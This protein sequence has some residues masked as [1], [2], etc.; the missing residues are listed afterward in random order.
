MKTA[1]DSSILLDVFLP[2]PEFGERSLAV[3]RRVYALGSL[4]VC[5]VAWAEASAHFAD[6]RLLHE[7]MD[8]AG[9]DFEPL[10][11][12]ASEEAGRLWREYCL[13]HRRP[14]QRVIADFLVGAHAFLQADA[15]LTRDRG[16]Y[17]PYFPKLKIVD[18]T[19]T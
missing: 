12:A 17:R 1:V 4:A 15:L 10:T 16:F 5:D 8:A 11:R 2:D 6:V 18:P 13:Q 14:R 19:R 3:L 9:V 7:R